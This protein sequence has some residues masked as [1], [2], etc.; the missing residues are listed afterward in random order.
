MRGLTVETKPYG[1]TSTTGSIRSG[2]ESSIGGGSMRN[3]G[4]E[5]GS[6]S[7]VGGGSA[8]MRSAVGSESFRTARS[9]SGALERS[10]S[11]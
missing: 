8:N 11:A 10:G 7:T 2:S 4:G 3:V 6:G 1:S 5:L 9:G